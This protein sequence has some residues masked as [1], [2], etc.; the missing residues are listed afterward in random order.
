MMLTAATPPTAARRPRLA[1]SYHT[2]S[3][4]DYSDPRYNGF[5]PLPRDQR[6]PRAARQRLPRTAHRDMEIILLRL[7]SSSRQGRMGTGSVIRPGRRGQRMRP[8]R[9]AAQRVQSSKTEVVHFL[10]IWVFPNKSEPTA[11]RAEDVRARPSKRSQLNLSVCPTA[12]DGS[13]SSSG[14]TDLRAVLGAGESVTHPHHAGAKLWVQGA[15]RRP[16]A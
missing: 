13:V 1:H 10:Q 7:E 16:F 4:A 9:R 2:F 5:G 12:V 3:F 14:R 15:A 6:G 8:Y 11:S